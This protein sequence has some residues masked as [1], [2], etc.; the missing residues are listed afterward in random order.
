MTP[1]IIAIVQARTQSQRLPNKVV[2]RIGGETILGILLKRLHKSATFDEIIVATTTSPKDDIIERIALDEN[3]HI[4]KGSAENVLDRYYNAARENS[5]GC[6]VRI[7]ADNPLTDASLADSQV[8]FFAE[9]DCDYVTTM[10]VILGVGSEVFSFHALQEAWRH[11]TER[12][13]KEHVTPYIYEN[14]QKFKVRYLEATGIFKE[15]KVRLT[16][17]YKED[18]ELYAAIH[19]HFKDLVNVDLSDVVRFLN[20]TPKIRKLNMGMRQ[21]DYLEAET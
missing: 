19:E 16:I 1:R 14:P 13:Q 8:N 18:L 3:T 4:F 7:T 17:D 20:E 15:G 6:I 10:N 12:Y 21:K 9:N 5:A 11:S 2:I